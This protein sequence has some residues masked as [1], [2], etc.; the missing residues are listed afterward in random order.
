VYNVGAAVVVPCVDSRKLE[1]AESSSRAVEKTNVDFNSASLALALRRDKTMISLTYNQ[2]RLLTRSH[3]QVEATTV[4]MFSADMYQVKISGDGYG[5]G[6][7]HALVE[8][9]TKSIG[10]HGIGGAKPMAVMSFFLKEGDAEV[11]LD[12]R[13]YLVLTCSIEYGKNPVKDDEELMRSL[14]VGAD[15]LKELATS[16]VDQFKAFYNNPGL[17]TANCRRW[18]S[19]KEPFPGRPT[20]EPDA[21]E[22][23]DDDEGVVD[24]TPVGASG[25][26]KARGKGKEKIRA[27][28]STED[29]GD[30][31]AI[32]KAKAKARAIV[33]TAESNAQR[34]VEEAE[35][36]AAAEA[37]KIVESAYREASG[38]TGNA[39]AD[40]N[41]RRRLAEGAAGAASSGD[42][43]KREAGLIGE[44]AGARAK[45][46]ILEGCVST[47]SAMLETQFKNSLTQQAMSAYV[48][49]PDQHGGM[50]PMLQ[51]AMGANSTT[52][53]PPERSGIMVWGVVVFISALTPP[54]THTQP[55]SQTP[56]CSRS[57]NR[58]GRGRGGGPMRLR[59]LLRRRVS[60][61]RPTQTRQRLTG[62]D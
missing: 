53:A 37:E 50:L 59:R 3:R 45:A 28:G 12:P 60:S 54:N 47:Q 46:T 52:A 29:K 30:S 25:G 14:G 34:T 16:A 39:H 5:V 40:K 19:G 11:K 27:K 38:I 51:Q 21:L 15:K 57:C 58:R 44:L 32:A 31:D 56:P 22:V 10:C 6:M 26:E 43:S 8:F 55:T 7:L 18:V 33:S 4:A 9:G 62:N 61:T 1:R 24:E 23:E 49:R 2:G 20:F 36:R 48:A 41:K 17:S 13:I 42:V 35:R